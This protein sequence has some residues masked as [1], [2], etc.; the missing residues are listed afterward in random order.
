MMIDSSAEKYYALKSKYLVKQ[1]SM[2]KNKYLNDFQSYRDWCGQSETETAADFLSAPCI[3]LA[4]ATIRL[5]EDGQITDRRFAY[6]FIGIRYHI[7]DNQLLHRTDEICIIAELRL[8]FD[9]KA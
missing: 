8:F 4:D 7:F 6:L 1:F 9:R 2:I 3:K 5:C